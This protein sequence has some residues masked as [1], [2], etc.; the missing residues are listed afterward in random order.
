VATR[1]AAPGAHMAMNALAALSA[2]AVLGADPARGAEVLRGFAPVS[3][4]GAQR[5]I[6]VADGE[7]LLLDE[8]YNAS[9]VAVRAALAVLAMQTASRRVAVL[10]DM[11]EL[12]AFGPAEHASLAPDAAAAADVVFTCGPL[13]ARL[14][15]AQPAAQRGAHAEDSAALAPIV[16]AALR[17]GDAVLVKG[18]LGSRMKLIVDAIDRPVRDTSSGEAA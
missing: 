9:T 6:A 2:A 11:R 18:S 1:L 12:G 4:R 15:D 3:G 16:A 10:G 8:S 5:R 13:M 7:A 17:P 14:R